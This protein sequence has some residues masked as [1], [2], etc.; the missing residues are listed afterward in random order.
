MSLLP[1]H[2]ATTPHSLIISVV[3][4]Q[5]RRTQCGVTAPWIKRALAPSRTPPCPEFPDTEPPR[6]EVLT[7]PRSS[8]CVPSIQTLRL[9]V[10]TVS[11]SIPAEPQ[12][13]CLATP[14]TGH[15]SS[16]LLLF[17]DPIWPSRLRASVLPTPDHN[18]SVTLSLSMQS[19]VLYPTPHPSTG[20][21]ILTVPDV[22]EFSSP[23]PLRPLSCVP[24]TRPQLLQAP[25]VPESSHRS[26]QARRLA[27]LTGDSSSCC[28]GSRRPAPGSRAVARLLPGTGRGNRWPAPNRTSSS[29]PMVTAK[30]ASF[31]AARPRGPGVPGAGDNQACPRRL[32][33]S[34]GPRLE[35]REPARD[36]VK[37][38]SEVEVVWG[39]PTPLQDRLFKFSEVGSAQLKEAWVFLFNP[40]RS[41]AE[42]ASIKL[43]APQEAHPSEHQILHPRGP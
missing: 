28:R 13:P 17:L 6:L 10:P 7:V 4:T 9:G 18:F 3:R 8:S 22:P 14:T 16:D 30:R 29:T 37:A 38:G 36:G 41:R 31:C 23:A 40:Q 21:M 20:P 11:R 42:E 32:D 2:W 35:R 15:R 34:C 39:S 24:S 12:A 1:N 26:P 5:T 25:A 19:L 43:G 27:L 33:R